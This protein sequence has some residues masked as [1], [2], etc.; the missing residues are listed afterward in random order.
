MEDNCMTAHI[1]HHMSS[2]HRSH[3]DQKR[4]ARNACMHSVNRGFC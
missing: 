1:P 4:T 2:R 3:K